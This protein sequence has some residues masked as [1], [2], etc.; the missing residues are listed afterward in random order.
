M[1]VTEV[2]EGR[3]VLKLDG[4]G[5]MSVGLPYF[6]LLDG[7]RRYG[8]LSRACREVGVTLKTGSKWIR[9]LESRLGVKLVEVRKGGRG[10]GGSTLTE[11][12]YRLLESYYSARTV[13]K[14]GFITTFIESLLSA[15][16]ILRCRVRSVQ[17]SEILSMVELEL[18]PNQ[19]LKAVVTTQSVERLNIREGREVLAIVKA[20]EVLVASKDL[21]RP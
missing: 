2:R 4:E 21:I 5:Y 9:F 10:G 7:V 11:H 20:T 1:S 6:E 3:V 12:A 19:C 16:N 18:E 14:P 17:R 8:T 13:T 15:R